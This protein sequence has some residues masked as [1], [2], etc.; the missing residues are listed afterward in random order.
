MRAN[1]GINPKVLTDRHL[2]AEYRE[3]MIPFGINN[4][5]GI[6]KVIPNEFTLNTGHINFFRNK[7]TYLQKRWIALRK[8]MIDRGY[9]PNFNS[10]P[11]SKTLPKNMFNDWKPSNK[12]MELIKERIIE[13]IVA[14]P[15]LYKINKQNINVSNYI[16]K[17]KKQKLFYV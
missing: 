4:K 10:I 6:A 14:K 17:L 5:R 9:K 11:Y 3:L 15:E 12:D 8:E 2:V 1:V 16:D 7:L 13:K